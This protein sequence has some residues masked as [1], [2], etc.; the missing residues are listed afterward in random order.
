MEF[1]ATHLTVPGSEKWRNAKDRILPLG[2]A[3]LQHQEAFD[4]RTSFAVS[5]MNGL[6]SLGIPPIL[7]R[8]L[9]YTMEI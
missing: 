6:F 9:N 7:S 5:I 3:L 4:S 2:H 8:I 1:F